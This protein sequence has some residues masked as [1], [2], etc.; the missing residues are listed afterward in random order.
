MQKKIARKKDVAI[1]TGLADLVDISTVHLWKDNP[2]KNDKNVNKLATLIRKNGVRAPVVCWVDNRVIYKGNTTY[3]ALKMLGNKLIPVSW[4][5]FPSEAAAIAFGI[6]DNKSSEFS[7]WDEIALMKL[8]GA[9]EMQEHKANTG[10]QESE[11]SKMLL[12]STE[13]DST[14][15]EDRLPKIT[16]IHHPA[17]G[18]KL[19]LFLEKVLR[20]FGDQ[21]VIKE[22]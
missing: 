18:E 7:E 2:R 20:R 13:G 16:I 9:E 14:K 19:H 17:I 11:L 10:F 22:R 8:M 21:V 3:K 15:Y 6:S 4:Q 1:H 5:Q 12:R